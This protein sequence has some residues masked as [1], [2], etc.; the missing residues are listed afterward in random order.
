MKRNM[1]AVWIASTAWALDS[2]LTN[3]DNIH[4]IGTVI[5]LADNT[6]ALPLFASYAEELFTKISQTIDDPQAMQGPTHSKDP[7]PQ[8]G[9]LS[10]ANMSLATNNYIQHSGFSVYAAVYTAAHALHTLLNCGVS[11][12]TWTEDTKVYPWKVNII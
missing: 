5:G 11:N 6:G 12:C 10:P 7:C 8:C 3:M 4:T 9:N 1:T 2:T